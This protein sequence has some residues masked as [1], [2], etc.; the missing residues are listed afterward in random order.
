[1]CL[2][3]QTELVSFPS[4]RMTIALTNLRL[5]CDLARDARDPDVNKRQNSVAVTLVSSS[6][7]KARN[8]LL[9]K[10]VVHRNFLNDE[11]HACIVPETLLINPMSSKIV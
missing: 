6:G 11:I 8:I 10:L 4:P 1:M 7:P 5:D 9:H 2:Q 3:R